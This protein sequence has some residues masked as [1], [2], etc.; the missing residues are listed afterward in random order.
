MKKVIISLFLIAC[1]HQNSLEFSYQLSKEDYS[2]I[3]DQHIW[4]IR[5]RVYLSLLKLKDKQVEVE[6]LISL[7]NF[8]ITH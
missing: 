5:E 1:G 8:I 6:K 4:P 7:K 3:N 2:W